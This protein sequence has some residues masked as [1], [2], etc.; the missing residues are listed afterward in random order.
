LE[1]KGTKKKKKVWLKDLMGKKKEKLVT[2]ESE[3]K[4]TLKLLERDFTNNALALSLRHLELERNEILKSKEN[5]WRLRSR[6]LWLNGGNKN[7]KFFHT[8]ANANRVKKHI[9][10]IQTGP[11]NFATDQNTIKEATVHFF[12]DLYKAPTEQ[13]LPDQCK[14]LDSYPQMMTEEEANYLYQPVTLEEVKEILLLFKKEKC[15]GLDGWTV[16]L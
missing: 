8:Y 9:W 3:I 14:L 6:A 11:D 12:K 16:E 5:Q 1:I 4:A 10:K 7:S 2:L 13:V 15:L